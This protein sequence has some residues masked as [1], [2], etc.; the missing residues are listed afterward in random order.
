MANAMVMAT[1]AHSLAGRERKRMCVFQHL[2]Q[3]HRRR[4]ELLYHRGKPSRDFYHRHGTPLS[5]GAN[6]STIQ[7][8]VM[9][10][11]TFLLKTAQYFHSPCA[12]PTASCIR[13]AVTESYSS[14]TCRVGARCRRGM[15]MR[16]PLWPWRF[17]KTRAAPWHFMIQGTAPPWFACGKLSLQVAAV[18]EQWR[19]GLYGCRRQQ[20]SVWVS[21]WRDLWVVCRDSSS[22]FPIQR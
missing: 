3:L 19:D 12:L 20:L 10:I 16:V 15:I 17:T 2:V 5:S 8:L 1:P 14:V 21:R 4:R 13:D 9:R 18:Q 11:P 6:N 22:H 7:R